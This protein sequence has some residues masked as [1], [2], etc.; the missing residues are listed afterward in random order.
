[1]SKSQVKTKLITFFDIKVAVLFGFSP[2]GQTVNQACYME[3]LKGLLEAVRRKRPELWPSDWMPK[4][5][6]LK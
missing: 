5:H 6:L 1:M 3:V 2:L 4:N